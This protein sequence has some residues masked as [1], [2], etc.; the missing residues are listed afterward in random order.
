LS[1]ALAREKE[2]NAALH[3]SVAGLAHGLQEVRDRVGGLQG[4]V[5]ATA[6][7][8]ARTIEVA[9]RTLDKLRLKDRAQKALRSWTSRALGRPAGSGRRSPRQAGSKGGGSEE[10]VAGP[11]AR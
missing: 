2:A 5:R 9:N 8:Q 6:E 7:L 4:D 11:R 3:A 10:P 1:R